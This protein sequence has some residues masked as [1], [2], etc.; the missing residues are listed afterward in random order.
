MPTEDELGAPYSVMARLFRDGCFWLLILVLAWAP[1]PLGSNREWS[2]SLLTI[3]VSICWFLW[4]IWAIGTAEAQWRN[5]K[6]LA[7]P[8]GL[9]TA[10][11]AW[12]VI[13]SLPVVPT[14]WV[15]PL[16]SQ[17]GALLHR[18]VTGAISLS[19]WRTV[20]EITKLATYVA[21]TW[22]VFTQTRNRDRAKYLFNAII[23]AGSLYALYGFALGIFG[24]TQY[25]LFYARP[26]DRLYFAGPFVLHNSFA[27]FEGLAAICAIAQLME[28]AGERIVASKGFKRWLQT[29]VQFL[30]GAGAPIVLATMLTVSALIASASRGGAFSTLCALIAMAGLIVFAMRRS[31][32]RKW[33]LIGAAGVTLLLLGLVWLSGD[34]LAERFGQL[35]DA[36][37]TDTIR[38]ALW[39]ATR[40]MIVNAPLLGL[41][42]GTFQD[43]YP[44]YAT[45]PLPFIMDKA[46][47][48]YLEFAA[49]LGLPAALCW[50]SAIL[51]SAIQMGKGVFARRKDRIYPLVGLGAT[52]LVAVHSAVDFSLQIP[53][54]AICFSSLLG[55]GLAQSYST[56]KSA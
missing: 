10:V 43:A 17:V 5:L 21:I 39:A 26:L 42:L 12:A 15:H 41:G 14:N 19:P 37:N 23:I 9:V 54:V 40:R 7:I 30:F 1:F 6:R 8:I 56:Q 51:W 46:H 35:L 52:V 29:S 16:W 38:I 49:G 36:G 44:M 31:A 33:V 11:L 20:S 22:M 34:T 32:N 55:I 24:T 27:T 4:A 50:W 47:S 45:Q 13:Q 18:P 53:A 2:W 48:D 28:R 3:L 25:N